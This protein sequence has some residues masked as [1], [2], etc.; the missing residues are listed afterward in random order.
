M[1]DFFWYLIILRSRRAAS[2]AIQQ[3]CLRA[4]RI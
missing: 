2:A 3:Y 4:L 1:A